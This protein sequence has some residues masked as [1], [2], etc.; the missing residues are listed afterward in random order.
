MGRKEEFSQY[1]GGGY[2][3]ASNFML[4]NG[5]P[6]LCDNDKDTWGNMISIS[7]N[8][9]TRFTRRPDESC[10][11][12]DASLDMTDSST[13]NTVLNHYLETIIGNQYKTLGS[14]LDIQKN[15]VKFTLRY[16]VENSTGGVVY[17]NSAFVIC[18]SRKLH[19]TDVNDRYL[20]TFKNL[21]TVNIPAMDYDGLYTLVFDGV[22]ASCN[23][24]HTKDH[25]VNGLNPYYEFTKNNTKI[26]LQHDTIHDEVSDG[27]IT[28]ASID[29]DKRFP[30]QANLTTRLRLSFIA[31]MSN[32]IVT[33]DTFQIWKSLFQPNEHIIE[34]LINQIETLNENVQENTEDIEELEKKKVSTYVQGGN[35]Y[36]GE[37]VYLVA[38]TLYQAAKDF[39]SDVTAETVAESMIVDISKGNLIP[40]NGN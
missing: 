18:D 29:L 8:V 15:G 39:V 9:F 24:I 34:D 17:R 21:M 12:I 14:V 11:N 40:V 35:Y 6:Y 1:P 16:H 36:T 31:Y 4:V 20:T 7:E 37:L 13:A 33:Y 32:S 30:F 22:D 27:E 25:I 19:T 5:D 38:G 2:I 28:I 10:V 3:Q 26:V 23:F